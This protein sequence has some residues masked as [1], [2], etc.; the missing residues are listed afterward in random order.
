MTIF[1][2][3]GTITSR[4]KITSDDRGPFHESGTIAVVTEVDSDDL[5][6]HPAGFYGAAD[7]DDGAI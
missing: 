2:D 7:V 5:Y 1:T 3:S 4:T 6:V